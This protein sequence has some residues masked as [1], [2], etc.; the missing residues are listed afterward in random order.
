MTM[1]RRYFLFKKGPVGFGRFNHGDNILGRNI[2]QDVVD[3]GENIP[4]A[5]AEYFNPAPDL[6]IDL[7][8]RSSGKQMLG[9]AASS[10]E[11]QVL[12]EF[13]LEPFRVHSPGAG[14]DG[15]DDLNPQ[16][17]RNTWMPSR[18]LTLS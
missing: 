7:L 18:L 5:P 3:L 8:F 4:S 13:S 6:F 1:S 12:S 16:E 14:L 10:P 9:V 15:I 2:G 11:S 17:W